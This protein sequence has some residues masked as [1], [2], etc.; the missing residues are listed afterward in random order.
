MAQGHQARLQAARL[1]RA[2][3]RLLA[4]HP[5]RVQAR[6]PLVVERRC[7]Q[8][9]RDSGDT[10][11][12]AEVCAALRGGDPRGSFVV[13]LGRHDP[14]HG[15]PVHP[16]DDRPHDRALHVPNRQAP[17]ALPRSVARGASP[18]IRRQGPHDAVVGAAGSSSSGGVGSGLATGAGAACGP[19]GRMPAHHF[20]GGC[21][22]CLGLGAQSSQIV[23][24]HARRLP[25]DLLWCRLYGSD[26]C[27]GAGPRPD[28]RKAPLLLR[29]QGQLALAQL[30]ALR[31]RRRPSA[32]RGTAPWQDALGARHLRQEG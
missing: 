28:L 6:W 20:R 7:L 11:G 4:Q 12:C 13:G 14:H 9:A 21:G 24:L 16:R 19:R 18:R 8:R 1:R 26:A 10:A 22:V 32:C 27:H 17:P 29:P 25:H 3:G 31:G 5:G 30:A 2:H 23:G 15:E